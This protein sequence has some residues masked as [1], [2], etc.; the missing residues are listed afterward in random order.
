MFECSTD[1]L[2]V[3]LKVFLL[4]HEL[5][6]SQCL[7]VCPCSISLSKAQNPLLFGLDLALSCDPG[8]SDMFNTGFLFSHHHYAL[9][10]EDAPQDPTPQITNG[11]ISL[12]LNNNMGIL[13]LL[14]AILPKIVKPWSKSKSGPLSQQAPELN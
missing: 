2:T 9:Q 8:V 1:I 7:S 5:K 12:C 14:G 11:H 13:E 10:Y 6:V 3:K 4:K